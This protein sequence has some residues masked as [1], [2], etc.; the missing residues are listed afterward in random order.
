MAEKNITDT[1]LLEY[2]QLGACELLNKL[3]AEICLEARRPYS[4]F[5]KS[6][7]RKEERL[8][9]IEEDCKLL[10]EM[11]IEDR[12]KHKNKSHPYPGKLSEY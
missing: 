11:L 10:E 12:K 8:R 1:K 7:P 9:E 3:R 4:L 2:A 5:A 6:D